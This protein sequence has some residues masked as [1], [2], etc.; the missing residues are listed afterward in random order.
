ME[1]SK[2]EWTEW[3]ELDTTKEFV[4]IL[5]AV[6]GRSLESLLALPREERD[7]T[8]GYV[9]ACDD[10]LQTIFDLKEES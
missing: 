5:R 6:R 7:Y 3:L 1:L 2:E 4:K 10:T 8:I 9:R